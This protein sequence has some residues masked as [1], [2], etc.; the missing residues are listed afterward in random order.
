VGAIKPFSQQCGQANT[1]VTLGG[2]RLFEAATLILGQD[3]YPWGG[4]ERRGNFV[5]S[6]SEP[7]PELTGARIEISDSRGCQFSAVVLSVVDKVVYF[8]LCARDR[9]LT[10]SDETVGH[11]GLSK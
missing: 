7:I 11:R 2:G 9:T 4:A 1:S 3:L 6:S 10:R 5:I 8:R